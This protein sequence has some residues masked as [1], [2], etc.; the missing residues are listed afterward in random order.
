MKRHAEGVHP[1][2]ATTIFLTVTAIVLGGVVLVRGPAPL[3]VP[4]LKPTL[5]VLYLAIFGSVIAFATYF[6]LLARLS[7]VAMSTLVF[8]F[9]LVSLAADAVWEH[10][11]R[12]GARAYVGIAITL[13]GLAVNLL[14]ERARLRR[15]PAPAPR[16]AGS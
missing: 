3:A 9:P 8:V 11:V 14:I 5:A 16:S 13:A 2:V 4:A 1:V 6:W 7:L 10:Q 12:L 15:L